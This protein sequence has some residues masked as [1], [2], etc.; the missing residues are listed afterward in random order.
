M[1]PDIVAQLVVLCF[2][3][4][5]PFSSIYLLYHPFILSIEPKEEGSL[6]SIGHFSQ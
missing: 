6:D 3:L 1:A 2:V 4:F 5:L